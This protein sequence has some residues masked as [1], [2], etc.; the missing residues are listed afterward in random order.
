MKKI[1]VPTDLSEIAE[2]GLE[3]ASE[4]ASRCG[5]TIRLINFT[6]HPLGKTISSTGE[7]NLTNQEDNLFTI[8]A[9]RATNKKLGELA[10]RY[11]AGGTNIQY[12]VMDDEFRNGIDSFLRNEEI[13][14]VV[15]GTSGEETAQESF[16]GNH[17]LQVIKISSCPV[18]SVKDRFNV[19]D[20]ENIVVAVSV[21]TDNQVAEGLNVIKDISQC[22]NSRIHLV[23]VRDKATT[24]NL[25]LDE[26]FTRM[27][28]IAQLPKFKV[29]ILDG[30]DPINGVLD[31]AA[32][33]SAGLIAILK[34]SPAGIFRIFSNRF[35]NKVIREEGR[36][37]F[38]VNLPGN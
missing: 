11:S 31:Y 22:F 1:L 23:H 14:L 33:V 13:D 24:S 32:K 38:T 30:Q 4:I 37:V 17:T 35:F 10:L 21:I 36:P 15:M 16:T 3:L 34:N 9:L 29:V 5:A 7:T 19:R 2:L 6:R 20:F 25:I 12:A 8:E 27:A 26:Y 28:S 18:L